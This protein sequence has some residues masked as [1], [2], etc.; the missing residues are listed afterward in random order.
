MSST[1]PLRRRSGRRV[2]ST[3]IHV[4]GAY[5]GVALLLNAFEIQAPVV[6]GLP[7]VPATPAP[8]VDIPADGANG[9]GGRLP[10]LDLETATPA[11]QALAAEMQ[12]INAALKQQFGDLFGSVDE[13]VGPLN[14]YLYNPTIGSAIYKLSNTLSASSLPIQIREI[15]ILAGGGLWGSEFELYAHEKVARYFGVPEDAIASLASGEAPVGLTGNQLIAAQFVQELISTRQVSDE[16]YH[17][18]EAA[19]GQTGVVD[20]IH[21][22][23]TYLGVSLL[24][25]AFEVPDLS[26]VGIPAP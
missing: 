22:A 16:L 18:A 26:E 14:A 15:V 12:A 7:G 20:I 2:S 25:N 9:L 19:F 10:M 13:L 6:V 17:A 23:S 11:Q 5:L 4:A 3:S 24:L 21:V 1:R 8:V